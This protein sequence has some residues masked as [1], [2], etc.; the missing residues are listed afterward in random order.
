MAE[1]SNRSDN[2]L[3]RIQMNVPR[4][5]ALLK[6]LDN[7]VQEIKKEVVV[8]KEKVIV[9]EKNV[10]EVSDSTSKLANSSFKQYSNK[11]IPT[12]NID[13]E[14][15]TFILQNTPIE[16]SEHVYLNG[17]LAEDTG[18]DY[19]IDGN[20][21]VFVEPLHRNTKLHVTYYYADLTPTKIFSD[22]EKPEGDINGENT[23][24]KLNYLPIE[25]SEHVYLNGLLQE[26]G[27]EGDYIIS[28]STITFKE[29]PER[30]IKLR[31]TYYYN[32]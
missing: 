25:G 28:D 24:F 20:T 31:V 19:K 9:Q 13:G 3:T 12:G 17:L 26:S 32:L 7:N 27:D 30:G 23:I 16:G 6:M 15:S 18:T 29:A 1:W 2:V 8:V 4:R 11:E 10:Q 21:I 22:K 5:G 14:N